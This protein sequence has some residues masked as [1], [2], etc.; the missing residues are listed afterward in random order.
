M[1][2]CFVLH[3][4]DNTAGTMS[5]LNDTYD[6]SIM[7]NSKRGLLNAESPSPKKRHT[8]DENVPPTG[9]S[10]ALKRQPYFK[11]PSKM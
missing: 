5:L 10:P 8:V 7:G 9:Q 2:N 3:V 11:S 4:A 1:Y 6:V